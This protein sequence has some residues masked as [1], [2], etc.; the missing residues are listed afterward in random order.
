MD[1]DQLLYLSIA[2]DV[3]PGMDAAKDRIGPVFMF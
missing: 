1:A 2:E 3:V